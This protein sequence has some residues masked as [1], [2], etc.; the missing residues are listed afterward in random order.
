[1]MSSQCV[2]AEFDSLQ[3]ARTAMQ[4]LAMNDYRE[5]HV[6]Y[7]ANSANPELNVLQNLVDES[8][9]EPGPGAGASAGGLLGG[10]L[11]TPLAAGTLIGPFILVGP[12]VAVGL[13][14]SLGSILGI[15]KEVDINN[16][17][18]HPDY[19]SRIEHGG[20]VILGT[21][22]DSELRDMEALLKTADALSI[23]RFTLPSP[24]DDMS[25]E[26]VR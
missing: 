12:L 5:E 14:A 10:V 19:N 13:G 15:S 16:S 25:T 7:I 2:V 9:S 23:K 17:A 1:M 18:T 11:A 6:S 20:A 21:G 8:E 24:H 26:S 3:K 4:V 22:R